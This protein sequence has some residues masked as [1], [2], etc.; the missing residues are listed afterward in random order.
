[1]LLVSRAFGRVERGDGAVGTVSSNSFTGAAMGEEVEPGNARLEGI[2]LG[3]G[4]I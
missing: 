1:M 2:K 3:D 4:P